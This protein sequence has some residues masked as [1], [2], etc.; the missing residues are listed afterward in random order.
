M[1]A[2]AVPP[3]P[4]AEPAPLPP[5]ADIA[6]ILASARSADTAFRAAVE[7]ARPVVQA[8]RSAPEGSEAWVAGQQ[9]YSD[10]DIARVPIADA[11]A[12]LDRR[13][14]AAVDAGD[15]AGAAAVVEAQAQVL[16]IDEAERALLSALM[17]A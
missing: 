5:S 1:Q 3:A 16:E 7:K 17:P 11:L 14:E 2:E 10:A 12:E 13:R 15:S 9:A 6:Q 4:A 8:G